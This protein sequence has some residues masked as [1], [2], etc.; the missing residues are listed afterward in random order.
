MD[1]TP[2]FGARIV[3]PSCSGPVKVCSLA[4]DAYAAC[5]G[6]LVPVARHG[7]AQELCRAEDVRSSVGPDGLVLATLVLLA[8]LVGAYVHRRRRRA[9]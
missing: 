7:A 1:V 3:E 2:A 9:T 4:S 5:A 8:A 6:D